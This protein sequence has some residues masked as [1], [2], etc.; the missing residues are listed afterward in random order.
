MAWAVWH[1]LFMREA[2]TRVSGRRMAWLWL[3]LEPL[4]HVG[5]LML[6][7]ST[8]RSRQLSGVDFALFLALGFMGYQ[9]FVSIGRR[10]ASAINSN[11]GLMSY[12]QVL[13]VDTVLA[14]IGLEF[15]LQTLVLILLLAIAAL[16]GFDI[17]PHDPLTAAAALALL[18][19]MG[20]GFALMFSVFYVLVPE[21]E[22][23]IGFIFTP[24]YFASAIMYSPALLPPALRDILLYNP[25]V[26]GVE[27]VRGGFFEGYHL[28]PGIS[29]GYLSTFALGFTVFGLLLQRRFAARL[30]AL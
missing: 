13:P 6:I 16:F 3:L 21:T 11:R 20:A 15:T 26:H 12:R 29:M 24:L 23:L 8:L 17:L 10:S 9:M 7:F 22:K 14:R 25:I 19:L 4:V 2:L 18:A 5:F 27:L 28:L 1:A 30:Q